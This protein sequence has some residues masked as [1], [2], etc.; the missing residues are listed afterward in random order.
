MSIKYAKNLFSAEA[1]LRSVAGMP[2]KVLML[3][4]SGTIFYVHP[5]GLHLMMEPFPLKNVIEFKLGETTPNAAA[6][7]F[8]AET[9]K[10]IG[11]SAIVFE[12]DSM[13]LF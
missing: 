9:E 10:S 6:I 11:Q 1:C 12:T 4:I 3:V 7:M 8:N 2:C 13:N 5:K